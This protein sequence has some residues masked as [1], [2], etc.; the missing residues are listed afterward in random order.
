[1][2]QSTITTRR[3]R[4]TDAATVHAMVL[5]IADHE[6]DGQH[7]HVTPD[8]WRDLLAR[9]DVV[10]FLA[11]QGEATVGY[12]SATRQLHLWSG[13]DVLALDDLYV[14]AAARSRG[15]GAQLMR[16]VATYAEPES[17]LI[18]WTLYETNDGAHRFYERLGATVNP[19]LVASWQPRDYGVHLDHERGRG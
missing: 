4:V 15:V 1:M 19:K 18:R 2:M 5:E 9:P 16:T 8:R 7:V 17:L 11:F 14:R 3:A 12:A 13:H 10:V 6:G